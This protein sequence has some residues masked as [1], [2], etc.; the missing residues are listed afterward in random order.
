LLESENKLVPHVQFSYA[1][2][3]VGHGCCSSYSRSDIIFSK[4][5]KMN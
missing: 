1:L 3:S 2:P 5:W 4:F